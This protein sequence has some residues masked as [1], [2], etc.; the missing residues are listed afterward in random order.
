MPFSSA[1][2]AMVC[3]TTLRGVRSKMPCWYS[4]TRTPTTS[5]ASA[6]RTTNFRRKSRKKL[7]KTRRK[8]VKRPIRTKK[9]RKKPTRR[10]KRNSS[11]WNWTASRTVSCASR[12]T[13]Q[14]W[15]MPSFRPTAKAFTTCRPSKA[16][17]TSG[18]WTCASAIP[19]C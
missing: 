4:S 10:K 18:R 5:S 11:Q 15:V 6:R 16:A 3:A 13:L 19:N 7:I 1:P 17:T 12:P 8:K 14:T 9:T 2:N